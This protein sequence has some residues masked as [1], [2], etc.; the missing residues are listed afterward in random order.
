MALHA[1]RLSCVKE[2]RVNGRPAGEGGGPPQSF[3]RWSVVLHVPSWLPGLGGPCSAAQGRVGSGGGGREGKKEKQQAT[4]EQE[5]G[6]EG[7]GVAPGVRH[8]PVFGSPGEEFPPLHPC[9]APLP[10]PPHPPDHHTQSR[11]PGGA[12]PGVPETRGLCHPAQ[13]CRGSRKKARRGWTEA[14]PGQ[15]GGEG[16]DPSPRELAPT[17]AWKKGSAWGLRLP[18]G[19]CME[20]QPHPSALVGPAACQVTRILCFGIYAGVG[21]ETRIGGGAG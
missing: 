2:V 6:R 13:C 12:P 5:A 18:C 3:L 21:A 7:A 10:T 9:P 19:V 8:N 16:E 15:G 14:C 11:E 20:P 17:K 1:D 4:Q